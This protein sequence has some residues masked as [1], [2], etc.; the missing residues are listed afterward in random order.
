MESPEYIK[1]SLAAAISLG[2][3]N[4]SFTNGIKLTGLNLLL[5]YE[6]GCIGKCAYCGISKARVVEKEKKT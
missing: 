4:G 1:T 2:F 6:S 3:E 5:T